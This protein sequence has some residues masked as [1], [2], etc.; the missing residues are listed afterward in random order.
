MM[1]KMDNI[2][3]VGAG[4]MGAGIAQ[5]AAMAGYK[6]Y[7]YDQN[8]ETVKSALDKLDAI[9]NRLIEKD[10]ISNEEKE[11]TLKCITVVDQISEFSKADFVIEAI[12]EDLKIKKTLF[13]SLS[14]VITEDC[15]LATNTSSLSVTNLASSC[16]NPVRFLDRKSVV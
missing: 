12:I 13:K 4:S 8:K 16:I 1:K 6:V 5:V 14:K 2:G 9:L 15:I 11:Q 3:I 7:L 10:R